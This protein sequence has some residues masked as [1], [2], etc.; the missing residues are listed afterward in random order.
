MGSVWIAK[1]AG[2][3]CVARGGS[4]FFSTYYGVV[5]MSFLFFLLK[6]Y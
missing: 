2:V 3:G 4:L 1:W 5:G 6:Y